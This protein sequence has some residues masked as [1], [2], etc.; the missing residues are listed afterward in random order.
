MQKTAYDCRIS[1]WSS[2]VCASDL[3]KGACFRARYVVT[4]ILHCPL[5]VLVNHRLPD[6]SDD[7]IFYVGIARASLA[8]IFM[9]LSDIGAQVILSHKVSNAP[10]PHRYR[11]KPDD[12]RNRLCDCSQQA[13]CDQWINRPSVMLSLFHTSDI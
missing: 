13:V 8:I 5:S 12:D 11:K 7:R 3:S 1:D 10:M 6:I 9:E 4:S 2:D